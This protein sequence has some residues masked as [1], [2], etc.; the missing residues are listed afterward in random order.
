MRLLFV[1]SS[2]ATF[3]GVQKVI[4][5]KANW[6]C[7][8]GHDVMIM[9]YEQGGNPIIFKIHPSI[10]VKDIDCRYYKLYRLNLLKR[11][12][13]KPIL[14]RNFKVRYH[15]V[16]DEFQPDAIIA[17][18]NTG[19]FIKEIISARKKTKIIIESHTAY[20]YD[21]MRGSIKKKIDALLLLLTI[22]KCDL[23][24]ALTNGDASFWKKYVKNVTVVPNPT[25][26]YLKDIDNVEKK[27][28][29]IICPTRLHPYKR[30][31]RLIYAFSLIEELHPSWY[32]DIYGDGYLR[33]QLLYLIEKLG[34]KGRVN[35]LPPTNNIC[36]EFR[37]SQMFVLSSD[38]EGFSLTLI[39]AMSCGVPSV[40]VK[41]PYGPR[42]LIKHE[43]TGLLADMTVQDLARKMDWMITNNKEREQ[44]GIKAHQYA[45]RFK[46]DPVM[47]KWERAYLSV[48]PLINGESPCL[49]NKNAFFL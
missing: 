37:K 33:G 12:I 5:E 43:V 38:C 8:L 2:V 16:I 17:P 7:T 25:S 6:L 35:I 41:C 1:L 14:R 28:G 39:E 20:K 18:T 21:M 36:A 45:E 29:R 30:L 49:N 26:F 19:N 48:T 22:K 27:V 32:I 40:A 46:E 4:V 11:T 10:K 13:V 44:M 31:D 23:L 47:R 15:Q 24:I 3:G 42:E 34:L 9:T